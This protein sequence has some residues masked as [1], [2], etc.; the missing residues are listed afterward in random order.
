MSLDEQQVYRDK[1]GDELPK[2]P[3]PDI[4]LTFQRVRRRIYPSLRRASWGCHDQALAKPTLWRECPEATEE[5]C[6]GP[7]TAFVEGLV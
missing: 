2:K 1:E 7:R 6:F 3:F 4:H 5:I